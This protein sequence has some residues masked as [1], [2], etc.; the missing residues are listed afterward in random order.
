MGKNEFEKKMQIKRTR[1]KLAN[2]LDKLE[3]DKQKFVERAKTAYQKGDKHSYSLARSGLATTLTP[4]NR[5]REMLLN[6]DITTQMRDTGT[7]T[8]EFLTGMETIFRQLSKV[9]KSTNIKSARD[10]LRKAIAGMEGVQEQLDDM[11]MESEDNFASLSGSN[12]SDAEIDG[13]LG[14][15]AAVEEA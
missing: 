2:N 11:L 14:L 13:L 15:S 8:E 6:I 3:S 12:V 4:L 1:S 9:N 7:V 10:V 5:T